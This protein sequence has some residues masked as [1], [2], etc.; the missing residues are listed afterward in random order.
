M[1]QPQISVVE[2]FLPVDKIL[3]LQK[4]VIYNL[5]F[6]AVQ[7]CSEYKYLEGNSIE[8]DVHHIIGP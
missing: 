7:F 6:A 5:P 3:H 2:E 4:D 1:Q 8:L